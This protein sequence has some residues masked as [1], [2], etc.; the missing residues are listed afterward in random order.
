MVQNKQNNHILICQFSSHF[1]PPKTDTYKGQHGPGY[2]CQFRSWMYVH[3]PYT[4]TYKQLHTLIM[5]LKCSEENVLPYNP[6][7]ALTNLENAN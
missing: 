4:G 3:E 5:L 1:F 6:A 7:T 2:L